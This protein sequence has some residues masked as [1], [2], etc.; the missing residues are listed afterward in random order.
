M[1]K[2]ILNI[3]D[4]TG[5]LIDFCKYPKSEFTLECVPALKSVAKL[6]LTYADTKNPPEAIVVVQPK[7][8]WKVVWHFGI[9]Q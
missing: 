5:D 3:L 8:H 1:T 7:L 6:A 2:V 9:S 4:K